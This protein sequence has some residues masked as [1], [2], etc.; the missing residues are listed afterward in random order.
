M[1]KESPAFGSV[2]ILVAALALGVLAADSVRY[3]SALLPTRSE[4][5]ES[6]E[7]PASGGGQY[8]QEPL[9]R[10]AFR[11]DLSR[12]LRKA[13]QRNNYAMLRAF[14]EAVS[15]ARLSTVQIVAEQQQVALGAIVGS[16]GWIV[17]KASQLPLQGE[18]FCRLADDQQYEAEIIKE[19]TDIDLALLKIDQSDLHVVPWDNNTLLDRGKW[20]ATTDIDA[21]PSAVGVISAGP[22]VIG[23]SRA[24]LGVNFID[25]SD[26]AAITMVLPGSGA[27]EAGLQIGDNIFAVDGQRVHGRESFLG[28]ISGYSGGQAVALNVQRGEQK[29]EVYARLMDLADE[30]LDEVEMEVNGRVS[31]RATGFNRVFLHDTVLTPN[32]CGGPLCNLDGR[33]VGINIARAGRVSSYALPADVVRPVIEGLIEQQRLVSRPLESAIAQPIR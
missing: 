3:H 32:Q 12:G 19:V 33:V 13:N 10:S 14:N 20:L 21:T 1:K 30:L 5:A 8:V 28:A 23:K 4:A 17:T 31:A 11:P 24:V 25:S 29:F 7:Q 27:D 9:G 22:Q 26:G 16:D 18:L 15:D 2:G 6:D